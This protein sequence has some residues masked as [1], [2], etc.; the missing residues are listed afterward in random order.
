[1]RGP[2]GRTIGAIIVTYFPDEDLP[3]RVA[4]VAT[5]VA[6]VIIVDNGSN[7][8]QLAMLREISAQHGAEL[9]LNHTNLGVGTALNRGV[10]RAIEQGYSWVLTLDQDTQV[11]PDLIESLCR[12]YTAYPRA[13][14]IGIIGTNN[15]DANTGQLR[16]V[17]ERLDKGF[18]EEVKVTITSGS[19]MSV[20]A[21]KAIGPFREDFFIDGIDHEYCLRL[22][23]QDFKVLLSLYPGMVHAIGTQKVHRFMGKTPI[24]EN[25][26]PF[27]HYYLTRNRLLLARRF[28]SRHSSWVLFDLKHRLRTIAVIVLFEEQKIRK[29]YAVCLGTVHALIGKSGKL[30]N[31]FLKS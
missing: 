25:Y 6:S 13:E 2:D 21:Y 15:H 7:P 30:H 18:Y 8:E 3:R 9:L 28:F 23:E 17:R 27:R 26:A 24:A 1:V 20:A 31:R 19:L 11:Y 29:L 22:I 14:Q 4:A 10:G 5:Q 12:V 16:F